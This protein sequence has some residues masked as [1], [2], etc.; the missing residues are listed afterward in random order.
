M[1]AKDVLFDLEWTVNIASKY[2]VKDGKMS[3]SEGEEPLVDTTQ[4]IPL[5]S[6]KTERLQRKE[7]RKAKKFQKSS[8]CRS[9]LQLP[10]EI[11]LEILGLLRPSDVFSTTR[12]CRDLKSLVDFNAKTLAKDI[13]AR[14]YSALAKCFPLPVLFVTIHSTAQ[15]ALLSPEHEDRLAIHRKPYQHIQP[16]DPHQICT[17]LTCVFAWNNLCLLVD[18]AYWQD[19]MDFS[20][21]IPMIP[22]GRNPEWNQALVKANSMVVE[23]AMRSP[24]WYARILEKHLNSTIR[25]IKRHTNPTNRK[26]RFQMTAQD[27]QQETDD[28]LQ[29]SGPPSHETPYHRDSYYLLASYL[30]NRVWSKEQQRWKYWAD[31]QHESD[32][33]WLV[34]REATRLK[35]KNILRA[36]PPQNET[37]P[38]GVDSN[39]P[40]AEQSQNTVA[41]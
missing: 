20:Q 32:L 30:P 34:R 6:K 31:T 28:F 11:L 5:H 23:N 37:C 26:P 33:E 21:P 7:Q 1:I 19:N 13:V 16:P 12:A 14:R 35:A 27:C 25:S 3:I 36:I 2:T 17:C 15:A 8:E 38:I 24:L 40:Q 10:S 9:L 39:R 29:R 22:R 18:F 41:T 4:P